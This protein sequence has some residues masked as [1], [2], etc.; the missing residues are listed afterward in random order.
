MVFRTMSDLTEG[1][2]FRTMTKLMVKLWSSGL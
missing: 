1:L 2:V